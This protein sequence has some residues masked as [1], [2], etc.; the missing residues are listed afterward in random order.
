MSNKVLVNGVETQ[1]IAALDRG[2]LY[3]QTVFE[4]AVVEQGKVLLA[5]QHIERLTL[6]CKKLEIA[7][8]FTA[9]NQEIAHIIKGVEL[10]VLRISI[11][12]GQGGR[13]YQNPSA[14]PLTASRVLSLHAFPDHP[15][16]FIS[17]GITL[18]LADIRLGHQPALAGIKHGNRLEQIIAR[19][20]WQ[21][22]WN[23][24]LLL[25]HQD[26]VIEATQSNVF[27]VNG[28][29]LSTPDLSNAGVAGVM[30]DFVLSHAKALGFNVQIVPLSSHDLG[31]AD[32]VFVTNSVIG[33]W[34]VAHFVRR[35]NKVK[36]TTDYNTNS[37]DVAHALLDLM[38]EHEAI[39]TR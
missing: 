14:D 22:G 36:Q 13:G 1:Q 18:G 35:D 10:A 21:D 4:T 20:Q 31:E 27:V 33:L 3:G 8:G 7:C 19:S 2:F 24:A 9:L 28:K 39:P 34:P 29:T 26:S 12:M 25:D 37:F 32:A 38:R 15:K 5:K 6:G 16:D 23:E 17:K 30:R 11:S